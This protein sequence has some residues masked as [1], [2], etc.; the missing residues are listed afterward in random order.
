MDVITLEGFLTAIAI[1][2]VTVTPEHWLPRVFGSDAE[3]TM[4]EFPSVKIFNR[5]V[6]LIMCMYNSVIMIF[7]IAP[8]EFSLSFF[9][10]EVEGKTY[11]IV[12]EWCSGFLQGIDLA[13]DAWM[14]LLDEKSYILRTFELFATPEG[15]AELDAAADE[16]VMHA[17]W[18]S[19]IAPTVHAIHAY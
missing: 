6:N 15:W 2:L 9:T 1:G 7:E 14:P 19:K 17:E 11:T 12:D 4:P 16:A 3:D 5:V 10:N 18:S 8:E 13:G